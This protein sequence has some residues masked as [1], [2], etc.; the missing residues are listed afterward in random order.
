MVGRRGFFAQALAGGRDL[1]SLAGLHLIHDRAAWQ[2]QAG[3]S[4]CLGA[5]KGGDLYVWGRGDSGQLGLG[6][7]ESKQIPTLNTAFPEGTEVSQASEMRPGDYLAMAVSREVEHNI[8]GE[9][10][11]EHNAPVNQD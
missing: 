7:R 8:L 5:S 4:H 3:S 1:Q 10:S 2:V 9:N 6:D 11:V